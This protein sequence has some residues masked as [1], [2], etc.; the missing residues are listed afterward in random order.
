MF[1]LHPS[2]Q[3]TRIPPVFSQEADGQKYTLVC[4]ATAEAERLGCDSWLLRYPG[5]RPVHFQA[6]VGC[7]SLPRQTHS[8]RLIIRLLA[9]YFSVCSVSV[10]L[11][12]TLGP[13]AFVLFVDAVNK[14]EVRAR[15]ERGQR[16]ARV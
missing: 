1:A 3:N 16:A 4:L 2:F 12:R 5:M 11:A 8:G 7:D 10:S 15:A 13:T 9:V 14:C 6:R